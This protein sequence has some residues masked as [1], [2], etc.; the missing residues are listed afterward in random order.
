MLFNKKSLSALLGA[1][2]CMAALFCS[3][4]LSAAVLIGVNPTIINVGTGSDI[5]YLVIDESSLYSTP[6]E[7]VYHYTYDSNNLISGTQFLNDIAAASS[8]GLGVVFD[9]S[10]GFSSLKSLSYG[11]T[12]ISGSDFNASSGYDWSYYDAGGTEAGQAT[13]PPSNS[14]QFANVGWDDRHISPGSWD[15]NTLGS[16]GLSTSG[17]D[18]GMPSV[19][20]AAVPEPNTAPLLLLSLGTLF[21][22]LRW[23]L[24]KR[25]SIR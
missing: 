23:K 4:S 12:T 13:N 11:G 25:N 10:Y 21:V 19:A 16:W 14:W 20:I 2:V 9:T 7:F 17:T 5:S 15:G 24:S 18:G 8:S 6:L 1:T 22:L 3:S